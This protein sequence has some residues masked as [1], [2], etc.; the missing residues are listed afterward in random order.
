MKKKSNVNFYIKFYIK[1]KKKKKSYYAQ[2]QS[3]EFKLM[4]L[5]CNKIIKYI[6]YLSNVYNRASKFE[7]KLK[8]NYLNRSYIDI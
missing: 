1:L 6:L 7:T 3:Q 4:E 5:T 8:K 2:G